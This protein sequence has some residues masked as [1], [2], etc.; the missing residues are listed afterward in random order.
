VLG[1]QYGAACCSSSGDCK[2]RDDYSSIARFLWCVGSGVLHKVTELL[3][4]F[5]ELLDS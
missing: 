4:D 2:V 5:M 3:D 1:D